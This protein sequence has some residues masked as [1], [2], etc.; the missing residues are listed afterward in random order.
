MSGESPA[1]P[2][3][4]SKGILARCLQ[5]VVTLA[6]FAIIAGMAIA[7]FANWRRDGRVTFH[8]FDPTW[9]GNGRSEAEPYAVGARVAAEQ[10]YQSV[11][12]TGGMAERA[13]QW[14]DGLR[15]DDPPAQ[16]AGDPA[17]P[18]AGQ[19]AAP[20]AG[21]PSP[22]AA[23]RSAETQRIE[24]RFTKAEADFRTGL[25]AYKRAS[26]GTK[27]ARRTARAEA[28]AHF[29]RC[30]DVLLATIDPYRALADHDRRRLADAEELGRMNQRF[31][32]D[33][34]KD[35]GGL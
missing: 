10:A 22:S 29:G 31:L 8:V 1:K 20:G 24:G 23:L 35:S 32:H 33:A 3:A 9:W 26:T 7:T 15:R 16:V 5:F 34:Q 27:N 13:E 4:A 30:R 25:A 11:W 2:A 12:G 17:T 18:P 6:V 21:E 19:P 14:L 28:I